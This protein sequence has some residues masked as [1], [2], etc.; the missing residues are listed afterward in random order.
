MKRL[1]PS[2]KMP[3]CFRFSRWLCYLLLRFKCHFKHEGS[4]NV[5]PTGACVIVSNHVS[6]LDPPSVGAGVPHRHV[7]FL[8]RAT[9]FQNYLTRWW[10]RAVG[11]VP[12]DRTKG[13]IA[14]MRAALGILK[15]GGALAL[16]PEGTRS[17]DGQLQE[18]KGGVGFLIA[19]AGVPVVP[20]YVFGSYAALPKGERKV[21]RHPVKVVY[22][23]PLMPEEY[24]PL[25][26]DKDRYQKIADLLMQR[27]AE[28]SK[29]DKS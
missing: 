17:A 3:V 25:L 20:A 15:E 22:G 19:K 8:A 12:L 21:R 26:A 16:F 1:L 2:E 27:I 29:P 23:K 4:E 11:V 10:C 13:D 7:R 24:E 9:L 18:G 6:M 5:P 28:L 14:A